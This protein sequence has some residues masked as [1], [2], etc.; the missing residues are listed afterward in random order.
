MTVRLDPVDRDIAIVLD[1]FRA[2][3]EKALAVTRT[4]H[5]ADVLRDIATTRAR[6][7]LAVEDAPPPPGIRP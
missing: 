5:F 1:P 7:F 6:L 4:H 2:R 3:L